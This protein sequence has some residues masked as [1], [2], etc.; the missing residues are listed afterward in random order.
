MTK[1]NKNEHKIFITYTYIYKEV[2]KI[3]IS[4]FFVSLAFHLVKADT[5]F[6]NI[7]QLKSQLLHLAIQNSFE[8][9]SHECI[10]RMVTVVYLMPSA[11][12]PML[13]QRQKIAVKI[14]SCVLTF[15]PLK[16]G[17]F[18]LTIC[19]KISIRVHWLQSDKNNSDVIQQWG[20]TCHCH[21]T[22]VPI[23]NQAMWAKWHSNKKS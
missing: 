5:L 8:Y 6:W 12:G 23:K 17:P 20:L 19:D 1:T 21:N 7:H 2:I 10:Q 11:H 16:I 18:L 15:A 14:G 13:Y 9:I 3:K 4:S 22:T